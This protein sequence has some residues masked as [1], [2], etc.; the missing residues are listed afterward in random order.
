MR[1]KSQIVYSAVA[2]CA[3]VAYGGYLIK[4]QS[5]NDVD[6]EEETLPRF[7][8]TALEPFTT[9]VRLVPAEKKLDYLPYRVEIP[10]EAETE[11]A[12]EEIEIATETFNE[13]LV[14][15]ETE[16][17]YVF[18]PIFPVEG[19]VTSTFSRKHSYN[20]ETNDWRTHPGI[21]IQAARAEHVYSIEKGVVTA[22]YEDPIWG[23]V[24]EID[25]GEYVS[26]YK[27][28]STLIMVHVGEEVEKGESISGVGTSSD[29]ESSSLPHVHLEILKNGEYM[30]PLSLLG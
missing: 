4:N 27:N 30:D 26:V 12:S 20:K 29:A 14:E 21:D 1:R 11:E 5:T 13:S 15:K 16:P 22:C 6:I 2:I 24:I 18:T 3:L 10:T 9:S 28:L 7:T 17:Q 8:N 19:E 23:N 25:H